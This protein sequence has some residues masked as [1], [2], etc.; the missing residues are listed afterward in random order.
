MNDDADLLRRFAEHHDEACFRQL[1]E[2]RIGFVYAV[3]LRRLRDPHLAQDATQAVFIA[4]ARKAAS[5]ARGPSVMGWLHRSAGYECRNLLRAHFRRA[6]R[7]TEA[8]RRGTAGGEANS[9]GSPADLEAVLDDVLADLPD[10]DREAILARY[11]SAQSFAEIGTA[12]GRSENAARMRVERALAKLRDRLQRR[13][14][15]STAAVLAGALPSYAA[16]AVP[17]GLTA[18]VSNT[19]LAGLGAAGAVTATFLTTMSTTKIAACLA[20]LA[21]LGGIGYQMHRTQALERELL[22]LRQQNAEATRQLGGLEEQVTQLKTKAAQI[23]GASVA[24]TAPKPAAAPQPEPPEIPGITRKAPAGWFKNGSNPNAYDV[25]VDQTQSWGGMPSAYAKS[26][27]AP[28]QN[29]FGGMM[30]HASAENYRNKRVRLTGWVKTQEAND[31]GGHLWLRVDGEGRG[32]VLA[33]DNMAGRAP[34][35]TTD[36][37]EHSIVLD[38]P[39]EASSLNFGFFVQGSGQIWVNA[40]TLQPVGTDVPTTDISRK[41]PNLPKAP[42]NLGFT[43]N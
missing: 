5:V 12:T 30:Q 28:G 18:S 35:G 7:E 6:E 17:S 39:N 41:Q 1:V 15:E 3:S 27:S 23:Q 2:R 34:K 16:S 32:N 13:G 38:V 20:G 10:A 21:A 33:F 14:F 43:P 26:T 24:A 25:G 31:G 22:S 9:I 42:V 4:L 8:Q 37:Q 36:W 29:G 40:L 19:A 11:F